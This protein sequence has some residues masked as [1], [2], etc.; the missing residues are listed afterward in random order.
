MIHFTTEGIP[1]RIPLQSEFPK[2]L[3]SEGIST[4]HYRGNSPKHYTIEG[5]PSGTALQRE[6]QE[7]LQ[8]SGNSKKQ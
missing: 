4:L 7:T 3:H 5:I 2:T 1:R 8:F 6:L